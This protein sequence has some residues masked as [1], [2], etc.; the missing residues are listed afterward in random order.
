MRE[1]LL[2][3]PELERVCNEKCK[4]LSLNINT[5]SCERERERERERD[6]HLTNSHQVPPPTAYLTSGLAGSN[7]KEGEGGGGGTCTS[8]KAD[9]NTCVPTTTPQ[10]ATRPV[11]TPPRLG[12]HP[13]PPPPGQPVTLTGILTGEREKV[14]T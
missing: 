4:A 12:V 8:G 14:S 6:C 7:G 9:R 10:P 2:I 3:N 13:L 5:S 11:P 1:H